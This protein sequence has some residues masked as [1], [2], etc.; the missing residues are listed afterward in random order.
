V[1]P[2]ATRNRVAILEVLA[3]RLPPAAQVLEIASGS[4]EHA[5][6]FASALPGV[7]WQP[8]DLGDEPLA[9]IAAWRAEA[10][11]ANLLPPLRLDAASPATWPVAAADAVVAINL[12]HIAPWAA[13]QGLMAGAAQVLRTDGTLFLYGPFC[14]ADVPTVES[15]LAFDANLRSRDP[16]WGLRDLAEV[17]ALATRHGLRLGER[18]VNAGQ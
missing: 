4:G 11:L 7:M 3:S 14:E 17:T 13:T 10:M 9:S 2:A 16:G 1:A 6:F 5:V 18:L 12:I 8:S 15:N